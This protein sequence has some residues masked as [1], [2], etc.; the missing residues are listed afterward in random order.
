MEEISLGGLSVRAETL[1]LY[2]ML[3][4]NR[5][6]A[7]R[8]L[9]SRKDLARAVPE[10]FFRLPAEVQFDLTCLTSEVHM[11]YWLGFY[12]NGTGTV[13]CCRV[14]DAVRRRLEGAKA[15]AFFEHWLAA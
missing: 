12:G 5:F 10:G 7:R 3:G 9:A 11:P 15:T 2:R 8:I 1:A 4:R 13:L 6:H 14:L